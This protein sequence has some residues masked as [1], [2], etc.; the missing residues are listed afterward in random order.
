MASAAA[1]ARTIRSIYYGMIS[2]MDAQLGRLWEALQYLDMWDD[3]VTILT[4]DHG[5][6]IGDHWL[7]GKGGY[8]DAAYHTPLVARTPDSAKGRGEDPQ[9]SDGGRSACRVRARIP[10]PGLAPSTSTPSRNPCPPRRPPGVADLAPPYARGE[11]RSLPREASLSTTAA[12]S[13]PM[14]GGRE[15]RSRPVEEKCSTAAGPSS[16]AGRWPLR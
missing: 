15:P 2:E 14:D 1:E 13:R 6:M 8:F 7:F 5:E 16:R 10:P 11:T 3:T 4:S 9:S 12:G